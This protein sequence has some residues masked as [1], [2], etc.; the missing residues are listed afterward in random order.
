MNA[1]KCIAG[2]FWISYP[3]SFIKSDNLSWRLPHSF[4]FENY[5]SEAVD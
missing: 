3:T 5:F 1:T 4:K 2:F